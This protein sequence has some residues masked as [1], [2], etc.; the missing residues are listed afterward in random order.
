MIHKNVEFLSPIFKKIYIL[1]IKGDSRFK[2]SDRKNIQ[3][4]S[5]I[6]SAEN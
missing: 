1:H 4:I 5:L 2:I 6:K 3:K